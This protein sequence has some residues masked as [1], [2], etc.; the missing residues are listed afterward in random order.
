MCRMG[1]LHT[2]V[3]VIHILFA[4]LWAGSIFFA[5]W[6]VMPAAIEAGP[7][8]GKVM[9]GVQRRGWMAFAPAIGGI[10]VLTGLWMY[11]QF[12][13]GTEGHAAATYGSGGGIGII[14]LILGGSIV[15]RSL[16]QA[17]ENAAKAM[18]APEGPQRAALMA[19]VR[20]SQQ[21]ALLFS[22]IVSVLVIITVIIM[23]LGQYL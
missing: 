9:G 2:I 6:F 7:E 18:A 4:A 23:S 20:A 19:S 13:M 1:S 16:K 17:G 22:R 5:A 21:R 8:G 15:G 3:R 11:W 10:T 14:A 12:Y